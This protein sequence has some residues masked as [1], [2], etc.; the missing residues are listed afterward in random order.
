MLTVSCW[1]SSAALAGSEH[2]AFFA[3]LR[4]SSAGRTRADIAQFRQGKVHCNTQQ[5]TACVYH[6]VLVDRWGE[7][8]WAFCKCWNLFSCLI[9]WNSSLHSKHDVISHRPVSVGQLGSNPLVNS[10]QLLERFHPTWASSEYALR[11]SQ[12]WETG[13]SVDNPS[14]L[15]VDTVSHM[16]EIWIKLWSEHLACPIQCPKKHS[17]ILAWAWLHLPLSF[18]GSDWPFPWPDPPPNNTQTI[19]FVT[20]DTSVLFIWNTE[21]QLRHSIPKDLP[22]Y[23]HC[24]KNFKP[25]KLVVVCLKQN[26]LFFQFSTK[27]KP[28]LY[29]RTPVDYK[30]QM[31]NKSYYFIYLWFI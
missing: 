6:S 7:R 28:T 22:L 20:L 30:Y 1:T 24:C 4:M 23:S 27:L 16:Q 18:H 13:P 19:H 21:I 2:M 17:F 9:W 29:S 10:K 3:S 31:L 8:H 12:Q 15:W 25:Y 11:T 14:C 26:L 5:Y